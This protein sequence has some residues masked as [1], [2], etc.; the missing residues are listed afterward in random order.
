MKILMVNKYLYPRAGAETY[1]ITVAE[2]L[3]AQGHEVS[4]FGMHHPDNTTLGPSAT[5][6]FLDFGRGQPLGKRVGQLAKALAHSVAGDA[7]RELERWVR[8][9]QPDL[10]HAHNIYNQLPPSLFSKV[11]KHVPVVMTLHDYKPICPN[12][13]LFVDGKTCTD[14]LGGSFTNCIKKRCAQ[15]SLVASTLAAASSAHHRARGTYSQH[16][17]RF[18]SPSDFVKRRMVEAGFR[19]TRIEVINNFA[20]IPERPTP[21]GEGL[22]YGGR[23]CIEKGV[24]ILLKGYAML[25]EPRPRFRIA[26][27]GPLD[28]ELRALSRR[29]NLDTVEWLGR[30]RPEQVMDELQATAVAAV[31]STWFENCSMAIMEALAHGRPVLTSSAGGNPDLVRSGVDGEVFEA[32]SVVAVRDALA[33]LFNPSVSDLAAMGEA[34][35]EAAL[36]RFSPEVHLRQLHGAY[37]RTEAAFAR[38]HGKEIEPAKVLIS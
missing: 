34:A 18:I 24:D 36:E 15:G 35:R 37:V 8:H 12:Y 26:G 13:S 32:G 27:D 3:L 14:C 11:A 19:G 23:L 29:L 17:H 20:A 6:P 1:M 33:R 38:Q 21:P 4:F 7:N 31:P 30:I 28:Q 9:W 5:V 22:F 16:Y 2:Q 25:P 10:I